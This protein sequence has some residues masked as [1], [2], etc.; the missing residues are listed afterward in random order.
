MSSKYWDDF[1]RRIRETV[2]CIKNNKI[3]PVRRVAIFITNRCNFKC[4]YCNVFQTRKELTEEQ[5]SQIVQEYGNKSILHITGGEPSIVKWLHPFIESKKGVRFHL[6]T[7]AFIP[8]PKNIQRLKVSLDS[9]DES[10]FDTITH[11]PGSFKKVIENIKIASK[12]VI[13]SITCTLTKENYRQAPEFMKWCRSTFPDLYAVFF[14]V[15]K[16][17]NERF[18]FTKEDSNNFFYHIKPLM[19][20]YMDKE[21]LNL[22]NETIDEKKRVMQDVRFPE[23]KAASPCYIS[24]SERVF[25]F[26]GNMWNCSHLY[27]DNIFLKDNSK[28]DKCLYG[29]N[30]RLVAFNE[31]VEEKLKRRE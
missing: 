21:S 27:R 13:T 25:D 15:Y 23:N 3:I 12:N 16:G 26:N 9:L 22:I 29:C 28:H 20:K 7:N 2:D 5:F 24:M 6:N 14:S 18:V 10:Y 1:E 11:V 17:D 31:E 30:R 8:P 4:D 19:E